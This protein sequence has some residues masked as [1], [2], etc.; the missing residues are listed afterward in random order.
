MNRARPDGLERSNL[1]AQFIAPD[2]MSRKYPDKL[3]ET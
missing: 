3:I 2:L 1:G